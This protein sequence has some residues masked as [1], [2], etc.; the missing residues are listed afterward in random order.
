MG[1]GGPDT[2]GAELNRRGNTDTVTVSAAFKNKP[3]HSGP[4]S[5]RDSRSDGSSHRR[6]SVFESWTTNG[7]FEEFILKDVI[8]SAAAAAKLSGCSPGRKIHI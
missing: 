3:L 6:R 7:S 5:V 1:T 4:G 2:S 8:T